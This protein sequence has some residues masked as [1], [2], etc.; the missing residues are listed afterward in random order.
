MKLSV[1][2]MVLLTVAV[3]RPVKSAGA[4][5]EADP[6]GVKNVSAF[7][8]PVAVLMPLDGLGADA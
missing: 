7:H 5:P 1:T 2:V 3:G 6:S 8:E 4:V